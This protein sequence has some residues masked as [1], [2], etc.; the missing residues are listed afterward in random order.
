M[1]VANILQSLERPHLL[2][3]EVKAVTEVH[4]MCASITYII[5]S[6]AALLSTQ[7]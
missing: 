7:F 2:H 3:V 4:I 1:Y 6:Y 5:Y